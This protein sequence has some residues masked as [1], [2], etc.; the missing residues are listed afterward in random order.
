MNPPI[1]KHCT[2]FHLCSSLIYVG[3]VSEFSVQESYM[4]LVNLFMSILFFDAI[5]IEIVYKFLV[6]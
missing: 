4:F 5:I 1:R 3:N 2:F 6:F